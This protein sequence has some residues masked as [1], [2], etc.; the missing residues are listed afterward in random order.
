MTLG[1]RPSVPDRTKRF[2]EGSLW[3]G[4]VQQVVV[5][6]PR[7][8][9]GDDREQPTRRTTGDRTADLDGA[10][11]RAQQGEEEGFVVL[12]RDLQPRLLRYATVLVGRDAAGDVTGEAWLQITRDLH[13]FTGDL[14]RFRGWAAKI[15]HHRAMDLCRAN[16]RRPTVALDTGEDRGDRDEPVNDRDA[17]VAAL[18]EMSTDTALALIAGLPRDQAQAVLLRAVVGLD[19]QTAGAV[20]GKRAGAVR[21]AAHRGLKRLAREVRYDDAEG[22]WTLVPPRRTP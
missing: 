18:E 2:R 9:L 20:L 10:L 14:D 15:V 7:R 19:A 3:A 16:A 11:H 21:V 13:T 12:Y 1:R 5:P 6:G 17:G 4:S 22:R 8:P